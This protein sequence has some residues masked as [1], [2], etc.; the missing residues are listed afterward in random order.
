[1]VTVLTMIWSP[2]QASAAPPVIA[3]P[4]SFADNYNS[5]RLEGWTVEDEGTNAAPS[6]WQIENYQLVQRSNIYG[7]SASTTGIAKPG[8]NLI[9]GNNSWTNYNFSVLTRTFDD[10]DLGLVFRYKDRDNYYLFSMNRQQNYR[11]LIKKVAGTYS[12]LAQQK[13]SYATD[14]RY[15]LSV[16]AVG[17]QLQTYINDVAIFNVRDS[18]LASGRIG[19]YTWGS[20]H[21]IFDNFSSKIEVDHFTVVVVP[22]TQFASERYPTILSSQMRWIGAARDD[23]NIAMV[24]QE[25]DI[26]D[27][28]YVPAQWATAKQYYRYLSGKVP[29]VAAAGNHDLWDTSLP[30]PDRYVARPGPYNDFIRSLPNYSVS[31]TYKPNDYSNSFALV[32]AGGVDL[33]VINLEYGAPDDV[34]AWA[35]TIADRHPT[36]HA[37][38][39][40]HD[41]LGE[42]NSHRGTESTDRHLPK[43]YNSTLNNGIDMW[44]EFVR[45]HP[46]IQFTFNGHVI[47]QLG[48]S[49]P[50][51]VGRLISTNDAGRPVY[52]TLA[53]FQSWGPA[54]RGYL[55]I[56]KFYPRQRRVNV[57][58]YSPYERQFLRDELNQ[59][60]YTNVDLGNLEP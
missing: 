5:G 44:E 42:K 17:D 22:D 45:H 55:R 31:G 9:T 46:N 10:D 57:Y 39:L 32:T 48:P 38:F 27:E 60:S 23:H 50:Y 26:V 53:N 37:M 43:T 1:M 14:T 52:Q 8:T 24:L 19:L 25:G 21:T 20:N 41:Y 28:M 51:S 13:V 11:R 12:L 33:I 56:C 34:L 6:K 49:Q 47:N 29:F 35:G 54:G 59:F 40:T 7:G 4:L 16:S 15:K 58:T 18:S 2:Q 30:I 3:N 36:R